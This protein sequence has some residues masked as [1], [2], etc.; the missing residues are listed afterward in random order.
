MLRV[1]C[2][3]IMALLTTLTDQVGGGTSSNECPFNS[4]GATYFSQYNVI[5]TG[6]FSSTSDVENQTIV[7]GSLKSNQAN[8]CIH[9]D[10]NNFNAKNACLEVN[11]ALPSGGGSP[12]VL[13]GSVSVGASSAH[14]LRKKGTTQYQIDQL[15]FNLKGGNQ[16]ATAFVDSNLPSKCAA[17]TSSLQTLS[18]SLFQITPNNN[19]TIP[20]DQP[21]P[22]NLNINNVDSN[23]IAIFNLSGPSVLANNYVQ[24]IQININN[25]NCK[26]VLINLYG[27][28]INFNHGNLVGSW[29]TNLNGRAKTLWNCPQATTMNLQQ[30]LQ[31]A[32]LAPNAV[33]QAS[34]NIDGATA[35]KSLTTQSELHNPPIQFPCGAAVEIQWG[36][37]VSDN[38]GN[39][40]SPYWQA[41]GAAFLLGSSFASGQWNAHSWMDFLPVS[42]A[43][44]SSGSCVKAYPELFRRMCNDPGSD[45]NMV[46]AHKC[47]GAWN[48]IRDQI[49]QNTRSAMEYW[50]VVNNQSLPV[51]NTSEMVVYDRCS[52]DTI[53]DHD[54]H[55]QLAYSALRC[56]PE[57]VTVLYQVYAKARTT[58]LCDALRRAQITYLS[59]VRP[60]IVVIPSPDIAGSLSNIGNGYKSKGV[61]DRALD[62]Y[63]KCLKVREKCLPSD[64]P[65]IASRL[66]DIGSIYYSKCEYDRALDYYSILKI[67]ER[68]LPSGHS[69]I[70]TSLK[71]I[72]RAYD[73]KASMIAQQSVLKNDR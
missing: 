68:C 73:N 71:N 57:A 17:I 47:V 35:V 44:L 63:S 29:I 1:Y 70:A 69:D 53:L 10:Q 40:L 28:T 12:N 51:F 60:D 50:A 45:C 42:A 38:W 32:L 52:V 4:V 21:G 46:Y 27:T 49:Q 24:Q 11:G 7:C 31:G 3:L 18:N 65:D 36:V 64:H 67:Q 34:S 37:Y 23:S 25:A 41:R 16:G 15:Q 56:I 33:V 20:A 30:N 54:E 72:G 39:T 59:R 5:T 6:D 8:Y 43:P 62:Y 26:F 58:A 48:H 61:Y 66:N 13:V 9:I 55:G 14:T 19:A 22:L 2:P